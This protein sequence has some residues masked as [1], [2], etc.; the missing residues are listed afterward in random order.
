MWDVPRG[1]QTVLAHQ[2]KPQKCMQPGPDQVRLSGKGSRVGHEGQT[3]GCRTGMGAEDLS[4]HLCLAP[5][6]LVSKGGP[7]GLDGGSWPKI[8][9]WLQCWPPTTLQVPL[10]STETQTKPQTVGKLSRTHID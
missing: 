1:Q 5:L 4:E 2:A 3:A 7:R 8:H 9:R 10:K 6:P